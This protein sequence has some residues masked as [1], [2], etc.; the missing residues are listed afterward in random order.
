M[1]VFEGNDAAGKGGSIRRVTAALDARQYQV[2]P[3]AAPTEEERAQSYLWRV[4]AA[5]SAPR[6]RHHFRP[7]MVRDVCWSSAWKNSFPRRTGCAL[8]ARSTISRR[9]WSGTISWWSNSGW[10]LPR[11]NNYAALKTGNKPASRISRSPKTIG[12]TA[13]NGSNT[14]MPFADMVDRTSTEIAPW[15][16][17]EANDKNFARIKILKSLCEHIE[18]KLKHVSASEKIKLLKD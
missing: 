10:R 1:V 9:S 2:V 14:S 3:I 7:F 12:A 4:L 13:R 5:D 16:L 6:A 15:I 8:T 11:T 17:V 18:N